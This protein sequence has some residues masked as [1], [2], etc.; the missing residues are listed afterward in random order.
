MGK[1]PEPDGFAEGKTELEGLMLLPDGA[2]LDPD[3]KDPGGTLA[4]PEG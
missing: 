2:I 3:G 4:V 1:A